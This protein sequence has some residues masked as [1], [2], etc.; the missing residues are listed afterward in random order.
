RQKQ[1]LCSQRLD[2]R[3]SFVVCRKHFKMEEVLDFHSDTAT[4]VNLF[5]HNRT[6]HK[7]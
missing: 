3:S 1:G 5:Q 6:V 4:T 7:Q 2:L